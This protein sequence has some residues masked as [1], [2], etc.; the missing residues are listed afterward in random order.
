LKLVLE[1]KRRAY[2]EDFSKSNTVVGAKGGS[3]GLNIKVGLKT[4]DEN[5]DRITY[6]KEEEKDRVS[7]VSKVIKKLAFNK[8]IWV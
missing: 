6:C 3:W 8:V 2:V 5:A 7:G 4:V 1:K